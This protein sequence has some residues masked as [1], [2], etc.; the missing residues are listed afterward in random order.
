MG[1]HEIASGVCVTQTKQFVLWIFEDGLAMN[2]SIALSCDDLGDQCL[3][4]FEIV[5]NTFRFV[6]LLTIDE[7]RKADTAAQRI[8]GSFCGESRFF[9]VDRN[10]LRHKLDHAILDLCVPI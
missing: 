2:K 1:M 3:L 10:I 4:R 9:V 8:I 5:D 7:D 6:F